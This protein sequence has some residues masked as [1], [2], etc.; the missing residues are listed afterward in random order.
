MPVVPTSAVQGGAG[1]HRG[2]APARPALQQIAGRQK[3]A[4]GVAARWAIGP[5]TEHGT[6]TGHHAEHTNSRQ[7]DV[8]HFMR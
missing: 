4:A 6:D 3:V 5:G 2:L 7:F 1:H 8:N